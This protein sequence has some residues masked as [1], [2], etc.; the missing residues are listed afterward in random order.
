MF[1][2]MNDKSIWKIDRKG[3]FSISSCYS[4]LV[5]KKPLFFPVKLIGNLRVSSKVW[6]FFLLF[7]FFSWEA[8]WEKVL[9]LDK[10]MMRGWSLVSRCCLCKDDIEFLA[11]IFIHYKWTSILWSLVFSLFGVSWVC[12]FFIREVFSWHDSFDRTK[13]K[14]ILTFEA[15]PA[16][17]WVT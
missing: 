11:Y 17:Y 4:S 15:D 1:S 5:S 10:L 7:V 14:A 2:D 8:T 13:H 12:S 6:V 3:L 16:L 9:T